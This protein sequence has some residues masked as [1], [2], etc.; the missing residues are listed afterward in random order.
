MKKSLFMKALML[1]IVPVAI[2]ALQLDVRTDKRSYSPGETV[3]M[4]LTA[5]NDADTTIT[6]VFRSGC[7]YDFAVSYRGEEVWRYLEDRPCLQYI[8]H[9]TLDPGKDTTFT[10]SEYTAAQT[11]GRYTL[12]GILPAFDP[13]TGDATPYETSTS[14][15]VR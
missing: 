15:R 12:T 14:F 4:T 2:S 7:Q 9:L 1:F 10:T 6:L 5:L 3:G 8:S 13:A 11:R